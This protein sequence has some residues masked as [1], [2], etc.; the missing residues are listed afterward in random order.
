MKKKT[1]THGGPRPNSGRKPGYK[2][3]KSELKEKT[4]VRRIP[5]S[6]VEKV[7]AMIIKA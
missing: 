7:D 2:K 6:L 5:V 1:P 3:P 4:V